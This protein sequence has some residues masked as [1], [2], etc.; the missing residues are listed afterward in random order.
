MKNIRCKL[1]KV[2][3]AENIDVANGLKKKLY[4]EIFDNS[5]VFT[6][7]KKFA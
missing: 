5:V 7:M 6:S 4:L 2:N 3:V 1:T